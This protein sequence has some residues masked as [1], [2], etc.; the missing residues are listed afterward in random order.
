ME[1]LV[2]Y[3]GDPS[4]F[5]NAK[6]NIFKS[7]QDIWSNLD[8]MAFIDNMERFYRERREFEAQTA[9][10][11]IF[12]EPITF[13]EYCQLRINSTAD[14]HEVD[15]AGILKERLKDR[16]VKFHID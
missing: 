14:D 5:D 1:M 10:N 16:K 2:D 9:K 6:E 11:P 13:E 3:D 7:S 8:N 12:V 15:I 4:V